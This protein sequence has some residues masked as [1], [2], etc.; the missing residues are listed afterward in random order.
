MLFTLFMLCMRYTHPDVRARTTPDNVRGVSVV[1]T[2]LD[3]SRSD[4]CPC[5]NSVGSHT[6][7]SSAFGCLTSG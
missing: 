7:G 2:T 5:T 3:V 1:Y 4:G 6:N